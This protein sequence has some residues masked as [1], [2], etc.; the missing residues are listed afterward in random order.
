M[1]AAE[2]AA[3]LCAACELSAKSLFVLPCVDHLLGYTIRLENAFYE[4]TQG[5]YHTEARRVKAHREFLNRTTHQVGLSSFP[6]PTL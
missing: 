3:A 5:H 6:L 4:L 2:R 1:I